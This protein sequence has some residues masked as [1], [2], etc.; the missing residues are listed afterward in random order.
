METDLGL[1]LILALVRLLALAAL[2]GAAFAGGNPAFA[3]GG[4]LTGGVRHEL[5]ASVSAESRAPDTGGH[6]GDEKADL[7]ISVRIIDIAPD[8]RFVSVVSTSFSALGRRESGRE[9]GTERIVWAD[10]KCHV[11]RGLPKITLLAVEGTRGEG[12]AVVPISATPR[13]IGQ[14]IPADEIIVQKQMPDQA[15]NGLSGARLAMVALTQSSRL[16]IALSLN[17]QSCAR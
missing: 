12:Q 1:P 5:R 10:S 9:S 17:V 3:Q 7:T 4:S 11:D 16:R 13:H 14:F 6:D 2:L 8:S 15:F